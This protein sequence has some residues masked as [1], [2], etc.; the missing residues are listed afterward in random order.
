MINIRSDAFVL[1]EDRRG[2][3]RLNKENGQKKCGPGQPPGP[4]LLCVNLT[5]ASPRSA[6]F[7]FE[8]AWQHRPDMALSSRGASAL[9][10]AIA[11]DHA[12]D[13]SPAMRDRF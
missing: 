10:S 2:K 7:R 13:C 4:H 8:A 12:A 3:L 5:A 9:E 11:S 1:W 6:P